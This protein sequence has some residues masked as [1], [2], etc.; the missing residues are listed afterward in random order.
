MITLVEDKISC[1]FLSVVVLC[2]YDKV[3]SAV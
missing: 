3:G 2:D 1:E